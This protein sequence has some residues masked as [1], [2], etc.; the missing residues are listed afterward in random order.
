MKQNLIFMVIC[1]KGFN[2]IPAKSDLFTAKSER[3]NVFDS[4]CE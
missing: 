2:V 4:L 3:Q 1:K